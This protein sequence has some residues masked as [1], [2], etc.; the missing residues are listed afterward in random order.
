MK[1]KL[2]LTI[3]IIF[4]LLI[5]LVSGINAEASNK[6][7]LEETLEI[8]LNNDVELKISSLELENAIIEQQEKE[9]NNMLEKSKTSNLELDKFYNQQKKI[10]KDTKNKRLI[11]TANKYFNILELKYEMEIKEKE[12]NYEKKVL[13]NVKAEVETGYKNS[14]DLF[15]Q[16]ND[17]N[18]ILIAMNNAKSD[19]KQEKEEF[20]FVLDLSENKNIILKE[21]N[22][23]NIRKKY[24]NLN[25]EKIIKN[26]QNV[27]LK[28]K[29]IQIA[30]GKLKQAEIREN[31]RKEIKKL[32]NKLKIAK[33][34]T[35]KVKQDFRNKIKEQHYLYQRSIENIK[36]R[37]DNLTELK[38]NYEIIKEQYNKGLVK[39]VDVLKTE[40]N[41]MKGKK[42]YFE[43]IHNYYINLIKLKD[44]MG[45]ELGA[46]IY[47]E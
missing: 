36:M 7:S 28:E 22:E 31:A 3:P 41:L 15:S 24:D 33:L 44:V 25:Y 23:F 6:L 9:I 45:E 13:E 19:F 26:N 21:I 27:K 40:I 46:D 5:L 20:Q 34:E 35:N 32:E 38:N 12:L 37:K 8:M 11:E 2:F 43:S 1:K 14:A 4:L 18:N 42:R 39:K 47:V 16:Q 30:E 10:Y 29:E 17:Y